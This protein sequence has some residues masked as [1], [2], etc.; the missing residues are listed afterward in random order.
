[1]PTPNESYYYVIDGDRYYPADGTSVPTTGSLLSKVVITVNNFTITMPLEASSSNYKYAQSL[2]AFLEERK[3]LAGLSTVVHDGPSV[4]VTANFGHVLNASSNAKRLAT[5]EDGE[6]AMTDNLFVVIKAGL[7]NQTYEMS[8]DG[9]HAKVATGDEDAPNTFK[10]DVIAANLATQMNAWTNFVATPYGNLVH[11]RRTD[12][13]SLAFDEHDSWGENAMYAM[14]NRVASEADLPRKFVEGIAVEVGAQ[15][16]IGG[17]FMEYFTRPLDPLARVLSLSEQVAQNSVHPPKMAD[18]GQ[19]GQTHTGWSALESSEGGA[20]VECAMPLARKL[21][22]PATM[23]HALL[24]T[25]SGLTFKRLRWGQRECG[26]E[27]SVAAPSITGKTLNNLFFFRN[28]LGMVAG[29]TVLLSRA[30][31]YFDLWPQTA[32]QVLDSDPIDTFVA[33][34]TVSP[35]KSAVAL[36]NDMLLCSDSAQFLISSDGAL[37]PNTANIKPATEFI[38]NSKVQPVNAGK[39]VFMATQR[40]TASAILEYSV[41]D[42]GLRNTADDVTQHVPQYLSKEIFQMAVDTTEQVLV[43]IAN[44]H[45]NSLFINKFMSQEGRK[46]L[47][48]WS[49]WTLSDPTCKIEGV[50]IVNAKLYLCVN[51]SGVLSLERLSFAASDSP[52]LDRKVFKGGIL[53]GGTTTFSLPYAVNT[54]ESFVVIDNDGVAQ[55][56]VRTTGTSY[57][58]S[59]DINGI[60][61]IG[62]PVAVKVKLSPLYFRSQEGLP[63]AGAT[64]KVKTLS[65]FH[66][67][68]PPAIKVTPQYREPFAYT[69]EALGVGPEGELRVPVFSDGATTEIELTTN[70]VEPFAIQAAIWEGSTTSRNKRL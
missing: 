66:T 59:K 53:S 37:T 21:L 48:S 3:E 51:H 19:I 14:R 38:I 22:L 64:L 60:A 5:V 55:P 6:R 43:A 26:D 70:S 34:S 13:G 12:N 36:S 25:S 62:S 4:I 69:K 7:P 11:V 40:D 31:A 17:Y 27:V 50:Q 30:G 15:G 2:A 47:N 1:M 18:Y 58:A 49:M 10:A 33:S 41:Q 32:K 28:R 56:L 65:L 9:N 54:G 46:V 39:T 29:T 24:R 57:R 52:L 8:I 20:W 45:R 68:N 42:N 67:G 63:K 61:T 23:P 44:T 35:L 16:A